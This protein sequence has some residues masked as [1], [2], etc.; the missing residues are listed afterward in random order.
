MTKLSPEEAKPERLNPHTE[1]AEL[2]KRLRTEAYELRDCFT[3]YSFQVLSV[4]VV[5]IGTIAKFQF[6]QPL[7]G[8]AGLLVVA[9]C[10]AVIKMGIHKFKGSSRNLGYELYLSRLD[11][12]NVDQNGVPIEKMREIK[13]E[14]AMKA[15]R[16]VE[17][18]IWRH[19][20]GPSRPKRAFFL[21]DLLR[22]K[23]KYAEVE[24]RY[25]SSNRGQRSWWHAVEPVN[26]PIEDEA[27]APDAALRPWWH[28]GKLV[29]D[30][31]QYIA[32]SYLRTMM[33]MLYIPSIIGMALATFGAFQILFEID[34]STSRNLSSEELSIPKGFG[35]FMILAVAA[36]GFVA[37]QWSKRF[38]LDRRSIE[39]GF[40]SIHTCSILWHFTVVAH[41]KALERIGG[42]KEFQVKSFANYTPKLGEEIAEIIK[43]ITP[44]RSIYSYLE[45]GIVGTKQ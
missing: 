28:A 14:E 45:R 3:K 38:S 32:G 31:A 8:I 40:S 26:D 17:P 6:D 15:W 13:W 12:I 33:S 29:D 11:R 44:N 1:N 10:F 4:S 19:L 22:L 5:A 34:L 42:D 20:H 36:V 25:S 30:P 27:P 39:S 41:Y 43:S 7:I 18:S 2:I 37:W 9:L 24:E 35:V 23:P 16:Y 21:P